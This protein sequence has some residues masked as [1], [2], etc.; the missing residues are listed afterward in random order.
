MILETLAKNSL[1]NNVSEEYLQ[2]LVSNRIEVNLDPDE[3]LFHQ[4]EM[5]KGM[6]IILEGTIDVVI[7]TEEHHILKVLAT[8]SPGDYMGEVCMLAPQPRTA[9][10]YAKNKAKVL[11]IDSQHFL[12]DIGGKDPNA[13]QIS[14]NVALTLS[15]RLK[16]ANALV[17]ALSKDNLSAIA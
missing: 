9:G 7:E 4:G 10:V 3:F 6:Y 14:H 12:R 5:G 17:A 2:M 13:L 15:D 11:Y 16:Q 8:L 1:F